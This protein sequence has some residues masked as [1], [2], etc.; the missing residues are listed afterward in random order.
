L[1][2]I[3]NNINYDDNLLL[4]DDVFDSF[5]WGESKI[6][7]LKFSIDNTNGIKRTIVSNNVI[8][9]GRVESKSFDQNVISFDVTNYIKDLSNIKN[10]NKLSQ[11]ELKHGSIN[12]YNDQLIPKIYGTLVKYKASAISLFLD[13][14]W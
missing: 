1:E 8:F 10:L 13:W 6:S 11:S 7:E 3:L 14:A 5:Q 9:T 12:D 4:V 2:Y